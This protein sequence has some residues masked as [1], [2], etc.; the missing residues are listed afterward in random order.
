MCVHIDLYIYADRYLNLYT[1]VSFS[2]PI[3]PMK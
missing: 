1:L 2:L 3:N